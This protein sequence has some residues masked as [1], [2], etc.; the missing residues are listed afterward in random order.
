[1]KASAAIAWWVGTTREVEARAVAGKRHVVAS[2]AHAE[3]GSRAKAEAHLRFA[4]ELFLQ[5]EELRA[6]AAARRNP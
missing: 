3:E 5:I 4:E 1:M 6:S 2:R